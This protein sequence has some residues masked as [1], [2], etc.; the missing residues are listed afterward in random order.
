VLLHETSA[1]G[2]D[3]PAIRRALPAWK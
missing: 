3:L 1:R 2:A